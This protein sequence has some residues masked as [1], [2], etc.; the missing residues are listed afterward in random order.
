MGV[1]FCIWQITP[2]NLEKL[3]SSEEA[4][5]AFMDSQFPDPDSPDIVTE[6]STEDDG[7]ELGKTWRI[8]LFGI[9]V[10][11]LR[12]PLSQSARSSGLG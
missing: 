5:D 10:P 11:G 3:L 8:R 9:P 2:E 6:T 12:H 7:M 1:E 4:V